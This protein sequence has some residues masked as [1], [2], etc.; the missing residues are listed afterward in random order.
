[1]LILVV[2]GL[3]G[4][5][6]AVAALW[7]LPSALRLAHSDSSTR[8][9]TATVLTSVPCGPPDARDE[10]EVRW[11]DHAQKA[12]LDGCGHRQ[13]E[14]IEVDVPVNPPANGLIVRIAGT[15]ATGS[16]V[17]HRRFSVVLLVLSAVSGATYAYLIR[18]RRTRV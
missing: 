2:V 5:G 15:S 11:A 6:A 3:V 10:V 18:A 13:G 9:A 4:V 12:Q 1:V 17:L 16:G 14:V 8:R 7:P